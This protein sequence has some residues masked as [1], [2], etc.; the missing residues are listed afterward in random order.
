MKKIFRNFL[1]FK[2]NFQ[3]VFYFTILGPDGAGKSTLISM[4][5]EKYNKSYASYYSHLY[6]NLYFIK[7]KKSIYP[8]SKKPYSLLISLLKLIYMC[9]RSLQ[10]Y[11]FIALT[12]K[13]NN[14]IIWCDRNLL[15]IFADPLRYR[16]NFLPGNFKFINNFFC[17]TNLVIILNPPA[18]T[19]LKRSNQLSTEQLKRLNQSYTKIKEF[20]PEALLID[21]EC[22]LDESLEKCTSYIDHFLKSRRK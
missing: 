18:E 2:K 19:I 13:K 3:Q 17:K 11:F 12:R 16:I 9:L 6:P 5:I 8:Y 10:S 22:S 20:L 15:D 4:L 7:K 1:N 14:I 21:Y